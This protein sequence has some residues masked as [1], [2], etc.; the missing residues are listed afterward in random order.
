MAKPKV[1]SRRPPPIFP[2]VFIFCLALGAAGFFYFNRSEKKEVKKQATDLNYFVGQGQAVKSQAELGQGGRIIY[3]ERV[4]AA[5]DDQGENKYQ[6]N[7]YLTDSAGEKKYKFYTADDLTYETAYPYLSGSILIATEFGQAKNRVVGFDGQE[8][9]GVFIPPVAFGTDF[10]LSAD[11]NKIAYLA[12][13]TLGQA[14]PL[15]SEFNYLIKVKNLNDGQISEFDPLKIKHNDQNFDLYL[16][17]G[18][19]TDNNIVYLFA[20][21]QQGDNFAQNPSGLYAVNIDTKEISE[22]YYSSPEENDD[23]KIIVLLGF[24]PGQD[25]FLVNRGPQVVEEEATVLRT[26]LQKLDLQTRQFTDIFVNEKIDQVGLGGKILSPDGKK[27]ILLNDAYYDK[28]LSYYDL[29]RKT[30]VKLTGK[31]E[32][33]AWFPDSQTIV[34]QSFLA[35]EEGTEEQIELHALD[36]ATKND[37][38]IYRQKVTIEGTGL[39]T[40][41]ESFYTFIAAL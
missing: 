17:V 2:L 6:T 27:I 5:V 8:K 13:K 15:S 11:N 39:N 23:K 41:G 37:Y 35:E 21:N 19:S 29:E 40:K 24:Y 33:L 3:A 7:F 20:Q 26:Q 1:K 16:P 10:I 18:I 12:N 38:R 4:V 30:T 34:Y 9:E 14:A 31:G 36:I 28:G 22:I 32:F 25:F